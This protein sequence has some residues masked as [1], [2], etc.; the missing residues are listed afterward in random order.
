HA[1]LEQLRRLPRPSRS[2]VGAAELR[3]DVEVLERE[4]LV[5]RDRGL[6]QTSGELE[7]AA[8]LR[9]RSECDA[10]AGGY[11][12]VAGADRLDEQRLERSLDLVPV[13]EADGE[14][15]VGEAELS[16]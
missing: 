2:R 13:A 12:L 6:E 1:A 10:R 16:R 4:E 11:S 9:Q 5:I 8:L 15:E 14:L 7:L 3:I